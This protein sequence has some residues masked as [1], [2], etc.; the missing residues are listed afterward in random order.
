MVL[1]TQ[2]EPSIAYFNEINWDLTT[3]FEESIKYLQRGIKLTDDH[4][5]EADGSKLNTEEE[6]ADLKN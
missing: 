6:K 4:T 1:V 5:N 3:G 2:V